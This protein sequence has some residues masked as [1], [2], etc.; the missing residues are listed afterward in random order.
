MKPDKATLLLILGLCIVFIFYSP[1]LAQVADYDGDGVPDAVEQGHS[2]L[3][4]N[5]YELPNVATFASANGRYMTLLVEQIPGLPP[6]GLKNVQAVDP[7]G[8]PLSAQAALATPFG[9]IQFEVSGA[10][11][12]DQVMVSLILHGFFADNIDD[13]DMVRF[14]P[15]MCSTDSSETSYCLAGRDVYSFDQVG[16]VM[17]FYLED[18]RVI[19]PDPGKPGVTECA[20][21]GAPAFIGAVV[22]EENLDIDE[23]KDGV[24]IFEDT[25]PADPQN[26][27]DGDGICGDVDNCPAVGNFNQLDANFN[28]T[29]DACDTADE[30]TVHSYLGNKFWRLF[31]DYD[32]WE[33]RGKAGQHFSAVL[34]AESG[35]IGS[36]KKINLILFGKSRGAHLLRLDR[37]D[38]DPE[39]SVEATFPVDGTYCIV[40]GQPFWRGRGSSFHGVY[41]LTL[42]GDPEVLDSLRARRSVGKWW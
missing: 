8:G 13:L 21:S 2:G 29:G 9:F 17:T 28:G 26:D 38:L 32:V 10:S 6:M 33:I 19:V 36:G 7:P 40:V 15:S 22:F 42:K 11:N 23:D 39:N 20:P 12:C 30:T 1:A 14:S 3:F 27:V 16:N 41:E 24:L 18:G 37:G 35:D 5:D 34:R 25:C 31:R 4:G